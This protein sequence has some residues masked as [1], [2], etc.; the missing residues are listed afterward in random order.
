MEIKFF[1]PHWGY[2]HRDFK[3]YCHDVAKAG[4]DGIELNLSTDPAET[5]VQLD[6]LKENGLEYVAQHSGTC[7]HDFEEHKAHYRENL[8]RITA[9]KPQKL[10]CHTGIDFFTF[11]QNLEIVDIALEVGASCGVPI[12]H[13][14]H[15]GRFP[16]HAALTFQYLEARTELRL[17]AD[18]S[19]WCCVSESLLEGQEAFVDMAIE[20]ADHI[21]SRVGYDQGPQI[22]DPRAPENAYIV[23]RFLSWWDRIVEIHQAKDSETLT[24]TTEF[25]PWPY[26]ASLPLTQQ[27]ISSQWDI[28]IYMMHL[29]RKRYR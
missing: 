21:H 16:Y 9:L 15:R 18:F 2:E 19:H 14:T 6:L 20:R 10:N 25:G 11:E 5:V 12:V 28:N 4:F 24:I 13:E 17:T 27:A 1:T 22:N 3:T 8:E 23:E 26:T 29:L 7:A